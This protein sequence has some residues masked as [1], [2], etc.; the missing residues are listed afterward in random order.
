MIL[1]ARILYF[2]KVSC[3]VVILCYFVF[4]PPSPLLQQNESIQEFI[5]RER[6]ELADLVQERINALQNPDDCAKAK[7][8]VCMVH[9]NCG[10]GCTVHHIVYC[11]MTGYMTNRTVILN[12]K[13]LYKGVPWNH[14]FL[15]LSSTCLEG[16]GISYGV[17]G[18]GGSNIS[19]QVV[20]VSTFRTMISNKES[21]W[22][23]LRPT[24][25]PPEFESR[26]GK[27]SN[28]PLIWWAGQFMAYVMRLRPDTEKSIREAKRKMREGMRYNDSSI[29][30]IGIHVRRTDKLIKEAEYYPLKAYLSHVERH[31]RLREKIEG[32]AISGHI[33]LAS[34]EPKVIEEARKLEKNSCKWKLWANESIA[35]DAEKVNNRFRSGMLGILMDVM[36]LAD[37]DFVV[38]TFSSSI[39]K[40]VAELKEVD[41]AKDYRG[42]VVSLDDPFSFFD[43][44][45]TV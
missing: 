19:A 36:L 3:A 38:C 7:K 37:C 26:L 13:Q 6:A 27:V 21:P 2:I 34:D 12:L 15:P 42:E 44:N 32:K 29:I 1:Q 31:L 11:L 18:G 43:F 4:L 14:V 39:C 10:F 41:D 20:K 8:L 5:H 35:K 17:W 25:F 30:P 22:E 33:F 23:A 45:T 28:D 24:R 40:L 9:S 16:S